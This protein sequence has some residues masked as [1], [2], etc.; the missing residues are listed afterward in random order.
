[1]SARAN[2]HLRV[3]FHQATLS[4]ISS[5]KDAFE[6]IL[7][8]FLLDSRNCGISDAQ[9][10]SGIWRQYPKISEEANVHSYRFDDTSQFNR[11]RLSRS[12]FRYFHH[13]SLS[14]YFHI[15]FSNYAIFTCLG[16]TRFGG[17]WE[18]RDYRE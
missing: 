5:S 14:R 1:M 11:R 17:K 3:A 18:T 10:V 8:S 12:C 13:S 16:H 9:R 7:F 15:I 4:N 6:R 2:Q